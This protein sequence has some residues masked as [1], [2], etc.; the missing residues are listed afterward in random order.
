MHALMEQWIDE[1]M[2]GV[3]VLSTSLLQMLSGHTFS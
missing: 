2:S 1:M 3:A